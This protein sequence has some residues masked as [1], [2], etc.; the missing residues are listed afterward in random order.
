MTDRKKISGKIQLAVLVLFIVFIPLGSWYYLQSGFNYHKDLMSELKD[1]GKM[2]EFALQTQNKKTRT[3]ADFHG[4]ITIANFY[5]RKNPST[6]ISMDYARRILGQFESQEDL[7]FLFQSLTPADSLL[8]AFAKK[9]NLLD[10]RA[11]FLSG[12]ESQ[13]TQ[14]LTTGYKIPLFDTKKED[15]SLSFDSTINSLPESYPYFVL[16]DSSLT[17]RNYYDIND[18]ASMTRLVEHLAIILPRDVRRKAEYRP[19]KEM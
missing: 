15:G 6:A 3:D 2:P 19:Q 13:M 14:L 9:E 16:I 10:K 11:I 1:Y 5:N 17:I 12:D 8:K 18:E 4:K 7:I